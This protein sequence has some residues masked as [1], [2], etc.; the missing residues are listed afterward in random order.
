VYGSLGPDGTFTEL[1][2]YEPNS[3]YAATKAG[4]DH[5]VRAYHHTYALPAITTNCS[6]NYGPYQFPEKLIPLVTLNA[7]EEKPLPV[8][9]DGKN[10]RDWLFVRDHCE[11]LRR[12]AEAGSPGETYNLGGGAERT[13]LEMVE[14]IC[15][16]LDELK[17]R[18]QGS[19]RD[20]IRFVTDRPGHDRRYAI[21]A[22]KIG[23]ELGWTPSTA[24]TT[25][26]RSTVSWYLDN[27]AW[28]ERVTERFRR[29]RLGLGRSS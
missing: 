16:L 5:L 6:N 28:C 29:D 17:P 13:T 10:V 21:D 20:L 9:G 4:A 2:R 12:V 25:G 7:L 3:P 22:A 1:S 27:R 11:G 8:Y 23:R 26:M 18:R 15:A 14:A 24:F 19:Y